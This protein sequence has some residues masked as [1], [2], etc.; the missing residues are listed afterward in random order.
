LLK[1]A[2]ARGIPLLIASDSVQ[3]PFCPVGSFDPLESFTAG[4]LAGQLDDAFDTWS[5]TIC[6]A[7]W[8]G[9]RAQRRPMAPGDAADLVIFTAATAQA[10][11]SRTAERIV[12][13]GGRVCGP[14]RSFVSTNPSGGPSP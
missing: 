6:R 8:L 5:D 3:D 13:R 2:R 7:D 10:W 1:E 12:M 4:V 14:I 9:P 11:P